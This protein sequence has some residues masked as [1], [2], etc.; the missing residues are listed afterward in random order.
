MKPMKPMKPMK[1][2]MKKS[3]MKAK[4]KSKVAKGPRAKAVVMQGYKEKT[5]TGITKAMLTTNKRGKIVTKK[6]AAA[7]KKAFANISAWFKAT[8]QAKKALGLSG[9]IPIGGK[10]PAGKALYAKAKSLYDA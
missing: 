8:Q 2:G 1:T 3:T 7:G 4:K 9:F 5:S 6:Q 10:S